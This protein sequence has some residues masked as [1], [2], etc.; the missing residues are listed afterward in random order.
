LVP[1]LSAM[2]RYGQAR[3]HF[4]V[5]KNYLNGKF[6]AVTIYFGDLAS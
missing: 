1:L 5:E 2:V 6:K 3:K 4:E